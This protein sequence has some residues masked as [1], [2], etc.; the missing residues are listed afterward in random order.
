M[1]KA[2][3]QMEADSATSGL[4]LWSPA[5]LADTFTSLG[6]QTGE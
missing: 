4:P 1:N 5:Q 6:N 3:L 2:A